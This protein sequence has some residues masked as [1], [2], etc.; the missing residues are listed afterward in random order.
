MKNKAF[1]AGFISSILHLTHGQ[2]VILAY[3]DEYKYLYDLPPNTTSSVTFPGL[4]YNNTNWTWT[5]NITSAQ[6][7]NDSEQGTAVTWGL[8][9]PGAN[10]LQSW[11]N[12]YVKPYENSTIG[13]ADFPVCV[14]AWTIHMPSN[15]SRTYQA[16]DNGN[17]S[18]VLGERCVASLKERLNLGDS[19]PE[20]TCNGLPSLINLGKCEDTLDVAYHN[21]RQFPLY[22]YGLC[23][24]FPYRIRM[25]NARPAESL[26]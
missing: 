20:M 23:K 25:T 18:R 11:Y 10:S 2:G 24:F 22:E 5:I 9:W 16:G 12:T 4:G 21:I 17:C 7:P 15:I 13:A 26:H 6:N 3:D 8:Q 1:L 14:V 19:R